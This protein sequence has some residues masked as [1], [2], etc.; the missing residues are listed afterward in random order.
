MI[1][2]EL[3][4]LWNSPQDRIRVVLILA[5]PELVVKAQTEVKLAGGAARMVI[6]PLPVLQIRA[7]IFAL[8]LAYRT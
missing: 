1:K 7:A 6:P 5:T 3:D 4:F 2:G 8:P